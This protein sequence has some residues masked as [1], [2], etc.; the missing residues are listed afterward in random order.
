ML[1]LNS[2]I[3]K[4][5]FRKAELAISWGPGGM[6]KLSYLLANMCSHSPVVA[7]LYSCKGFPRGK[8]GSVYWVIEEM[9]SVRIGGETVGLL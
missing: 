8:E 7:Y 3:A 4:L 9:K 6:D 1:T 2:K 5:R